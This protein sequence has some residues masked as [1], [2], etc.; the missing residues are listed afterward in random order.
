[1]IKAFIFDMD[2]VIIDSEPIH[3]E[4]DLMTLD[5]LG[6]NFKKE[7]LEQYVGM[8]NPE[9]WGLIKREYDISQSVEEI[10]NYQLSRK[11][12]HLDE[13]DIEPIGGIR[14]LIQELREYDIPIGLASSSPRIFITKVLTKFNLIDDFFCITSG[15]EVSNGKPAPD[16]YLE[17]SRMLNVKPENCYVLEDSRNGVAAAKSAG[18]QCIGYI[19]RNSG[20]QD[21]SAADL[22]IRSVEEIKIKNLMED[23]S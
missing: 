1:M 18:M 22:I 10:I 23:V 5:Y 16:V 4:V 11:I 8:T 2:G 21:L 20:N 12:E 13:I 15:E 7:M 9:M 14:E 19:N 6:I 3:F 17:V